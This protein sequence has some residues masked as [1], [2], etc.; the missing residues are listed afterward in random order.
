[1]KDSEFCFTHN[2]EAS[3]A[4]YQAVVKGGSS[5][6]KNYSPLAPVVISDSNSVVKL[7]ATTIN[8]V[9]KGEIDLR[10]ANCIGYLSGHL[11]KALEVSEIGNRME[12]IER[13]ILEKK[14]TR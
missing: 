4:K 2:P 1:M 5:P 8:E 14:T 13:V 12:T 3:E 7:L 10:V 9:R 6:K 11:I